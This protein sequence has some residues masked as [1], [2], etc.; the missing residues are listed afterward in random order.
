MKRTTALTGVVVLVAGAAAMGWFF[1]SQIRSPAEIAA[2]AEPPPASNITVE[3]ERTELSADVITRADVVYDQPATLSLSGSFAEQP[4]ALVVTQAVDEDAELAEGAMAV[5]VA[6]RPVFLLTGDIPMYRDL[7]PGSTGDDVFQVEEALNRLG[8]FTSTPDSTWDE[9]TGAAVAAWYNEAGYRPNGLSDADEESLTAARERVR[10]SEAAL[11]DAL[12]ALN[13]ANQ[14]AG[15]SAVLSA[16]AEI[17]AA[18]SAL[19]LAEIDAARANEVAKDD[20]ATATDD[21]ADARNAYDDAV[22]ALES[23]KRPGLPGGEPLT[24]E[25]LAE[26]QAA[27]DETESAV[28]ATERTLDGAE[29]AVTRV[30]SEQ[31][32]FVEQAED[33]LDVARASLSDLQRGSDTAAIARQVETAR[34]EVGA[35]RTAMA[36]LEAELGTWL[37]AGEVVF[38]NRL[39]VRVDQVSVARGS[40]IT[41]SFLTVS[42]SAVTVQAAVTERDAVLLEPDMPVQIENPETGV[43]VPGVIAEVADEPG[44]RNVGADRY[45]VE[46]TPEDLPDELIGMNLRVVI[47]VSSTGGAVLA[48]PAAALSATADGS[49]IIE[50]ENDDGTL[51]TVTVETG[52]AAD[53]LVEITP[54]DG[55]VEQGDQVV[56]GRADASEEP[57]DS[58]EG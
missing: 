45:Y 33:R 27:V 21:L 14:G 11:A 3:V 50:V 41:G 40:V 49:T 9:A 36:E 10:G 2:D 47:P 56:I 20:V 34:T 1:G 48:V 7:R 52:L 46:I 31:R 6:G 30:A 23:A 5:E 54:V 22:A 15:R 26:L 18:A 8:Y 25:R 42:G 24:P 4:E 53:G 16:Q 29:F 58:T 39:P 28:E 55:E 51:R 32:A 57:T 38:L 43:P 37:P 44:T 13:D 12:T 17:D 35:A 19:D